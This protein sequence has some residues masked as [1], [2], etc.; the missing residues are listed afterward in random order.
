M[1]IYKF[2]DKY[3]DSVDK[4][5]DTGVKFNKK[6][7]LHLMA[8]KVANPMPQESASSSL[9]ACFGQIKS[10]AHD[11]AITHQYE[12]L[13]FGAGFWMTGSGASHS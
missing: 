5:R 13:V 10:V 2:C 11:V 1:L 4:S 9:N 6:V 8:G 3:L 12:S 7:G